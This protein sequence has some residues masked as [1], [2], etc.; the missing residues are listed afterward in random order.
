MLIKNLDV[1]AGLCNGTRLQVL[2][3]YEYNLECRFLVGSKAKS[4]DV[5]LIPKIKLE[6]DE[7]GRDGNPRFQRI[8]FPVRLC[9]GM[10]INKVTNYQNII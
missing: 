4:D 1:S 2:K 6:H 7:E 3:M 10:T 8:Q 5:V 9:F